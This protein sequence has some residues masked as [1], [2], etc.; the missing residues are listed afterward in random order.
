VETFNIPE[1]KKGQASAEQCQSDVD[2]FDSR[3]VVHHEYVPQGQNF[4]KEYYLEVLHRFH[5][6]VLRK[7]QTCGNVAAAS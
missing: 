3:G 2:R 4:N 6:A 5:D 7:D 1:A